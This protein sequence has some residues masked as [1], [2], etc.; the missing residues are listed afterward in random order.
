MCQSE[1]EGGRHRSFAFP[2]T[3]VVTTGRDNAQGAPYTGEHKPTT[4]MIPQEETTQGSPYASVS[5]GPL[6][7]SLPIP[8]TKDANTP[9]PSARWKFALDVQNPNVSVER[10]AL[11]TRW[12]WPLESPLRLKVNA[13]AIDWTPMPEAPQLPGLPVMRQGP[14]EKITLI[15]YG[16]TKFR[17]S[18]FPVI[19]ESRGQG[20]CGLPGSRFSSRTSVLKLTASTGRTSSCR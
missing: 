6:L 16:C 9:D 13:I 1:L 18:M 11:P 17:I 10:Q 20:Q 4:V 3:A 7:F 15:P 19:A 5:Y 2:M 14:S 8:D 12:N